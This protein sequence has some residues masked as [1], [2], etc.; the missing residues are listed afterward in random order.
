MGSNMF[1]EIIARGNQ[2]KDVFGSVTSGLYGVLLS[3]ATQGIIE[4]NIIDNTAEEDAV[5]LAN[6]GSV[7]TFNN[8][9]SG[10]ELLR[11]WNASS[12]QA[13]LELADWVQDSL[14]GI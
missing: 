4:N 10:G 14:L 3:G 2:I 1:T 6:C 12:S 13:Q 11:G 9:T 8:Q 7:K 5:R